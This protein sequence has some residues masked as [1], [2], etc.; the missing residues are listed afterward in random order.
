MARNEP[1]P[2]DKGK[3]KAYGP[4]TRASPRL[5]ALRSQPAANP[6]TETPVTPTISASTSSMLPKKRPT[7]KVVGEG[8]SKAATQSFKSDPEPEPEKVEEAED[9]E[10]DPEEDPVEA[11][12]GTGIEEEDEEDPEEDP[13]EENV[14]EEGVRIEDDFAD[15]WALAKI[16]AEVAKED[17]RNGK[18]RGKAWRPNSDAYAYA[19][20]F[21]CV[22]IAKT[23]A[24]RP[25]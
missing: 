16:G 4:P 2:S 8:T 10:E 23:W 24:A 15:Y 25:S 5:A 19:P 17:A 12:Q 1:S 9:M 11:P 13:M 7:Q 14:A 18:S 20:R 21:M 3:A 6:Q 22:R